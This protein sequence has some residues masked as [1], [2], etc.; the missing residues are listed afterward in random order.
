MQFGWTVGG[1][2]D[3]RNQA[4][5]GLHHRRV[6]L[7]CRRP[8]R[9]ADEP[10][11]LPVEASPTAKNPALRSSSL[12]WARSR[13][14]SASASGVERE[15]GQITASVTP[16]RTHSSTRVALKV[17]CTLTR[18]AT[19]RRSARF[20]SPVGRSARLHADGAPLGPFGNHL[21]DFRTLIAVDLPG[22][23]DSSAVRADLPA[24][25]SLVAESVRAVIGDEPC[26]L[27]GYSLAGRVALHVLT[28]SELVPGR[29]VLIGATAGMEDPADRS[30]GACPTKQRRTPSEALAM[31]TVPSGLAG[32][33]NVRADL[34]DDSLTAPNVSATAH[35]AWPAWSLRL[36]GTG[37]Q[38]PLWEVL[39]ELS[40]PF[41][42]WP[43]RT[44]RGTRHTHFG[45]PALHRMPLPPSSPVVVTPCIWPSPT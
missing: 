7:R 12:T 18:R 41:S 31:S 17:A 40:C 10:V 13:S 26:D 30:V 9:H 14:A 38:A 43:E 1:A 34:L 27:L 33:S 3:E 42:P 22:H 20:G 25:A 24:T 21:A 35:P 28:G 11:G 44:T 39:S 37:T 4:L 2:D 23:G 6:Q 32:R 36:T 19:P 8:T 45:W 16:S 15:P 5:I 29:A